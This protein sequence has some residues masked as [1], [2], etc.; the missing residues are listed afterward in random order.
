MLE[1][2]LIGMGTECVVFDFH[3]PSAARVLLAMPVP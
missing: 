1:V 2:T 3:L